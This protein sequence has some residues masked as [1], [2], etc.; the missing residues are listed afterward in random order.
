MVFRRDEF[1]SMNTIAIPARNRAQIRE[2]TSPTVFILF[3]S[4]LFLS[5]FLLFQVQLI[6]SKY[7]LPWF[8][9]TAAVWTTSMLVFQL[10]LLAGY[11]YSHVI[12]VR[13]PARMQIWL[14]LGLLAAA[15][16]LV[17]TLP[18]FWPSAITPGLSWKPRDVSTPVRDVATILLAS[19]GVPFFLLSTTGPLLQRWFAGLGGGEKTYKLYSVSNLGSLLGLLLFPSLLETTLRVKQQA[20]LWSLLFF[21]FVMGCSGCA[22][23]ARE[24][25]YEPAVKEN[26]S[27]P[28]NKIHTGLSL[29]LWF[30][31]A[32]CAS[33]LLLATTNLL[34]QEVISVPLLWVLPL[35]LYLLSFILCFDHPRWYQRA[36]IH[37]LFALAL[38][39][40][41]AAL[42]FD[43]HKAQAMALPPLLFLACM[44]CHGELYRL[45][46][47][48]QQLTWFY[49]TVAAG[50]A[51]G[52]VFV[53]IVA[54][55]LFTSFVEFQLSTGASLILVLVCLLLDR[56]SWIFTHRFAVPAA[57][58]GCVL[59][60][61]YA[62]GLLHPEAARALQELRFYPITLMI[63]ILASVGAFLRI[64][65]TSEERGFRFVQVP[66]IC[67]A[68]LGLLALYQ[69]SRAPS[70]LIVSTRNF[71]GV[72]RVMRGGYGKF[73]KHGGTIHGAQ[74][75]PPWQ[76]Q[77]STYYGP[78]SGVGIVIRNHPKRG[79]SPGTLRV[80][81]VGLGV[82][83]LLAYGVPGDDFRIYELDPDV[84]Q[85]SSGPQPMFTFAK[86]SAA[87]KE[88]VLG[89][90]RLLLEAEASRGEFQNFDLLVL[91]A[92]SGDAVPV[93]L[94]TREAFEA[95][96][97]HMNPQSGIIAV[98]IST[99]HVDLL[100]VVQGVIKYYEADSVVRTTLDRDPN[101]PSV[102]VLLSRSPGALKIRGLEEMLPPDRK[103]VAPRLWTDDF[104]NVMGLLH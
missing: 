34:C 102:W 104:S 9:G 13:L 100:P 65:G 16:L 41:C 70:N 24:G 74:Y 18:F 45:K 60:A 91:D 39:T 2:G 95:Y 7:I 14:H 37:P 4:T 33:S 63:G 79:F 31:L 96:W 78:N 93:H 29:G 32:A 64:D 3:A 76:K 12:S 54:P 58:S 94:L 26:Q 67:L 83:T 38:F 80:G 88:F 57:I 101:L 55:R 36:A 82:G 27:E 51:A 84:L 21:A 77:P 28:E 25:S 30:L 52:G 87:R 50:G 89:D 5:A 81:L 15:F 62:G 17:F 75:D 56:E 68:I 6:V 59:I 1:E 49:L 90:G 35:S 97:K 22:W 47:R 66:V 73:L 61:G 48:V 86:D 53:G 99:R 71:Y 8:G 46:P 92:F 23:K 103:P 85:L 19:A 43:L 42:V 69:S 20:T 72:L 10:L 11:L 98:H 40:A 44:V